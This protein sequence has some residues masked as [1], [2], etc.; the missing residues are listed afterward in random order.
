MEWR[1]RQEKAS[2]EI[3]AAAGENSD[4]KEN[5]DAKKRTDTGERKDTREKPN[6]K[7]NS[8]V[9]EGTDTGERKD[10]REKSDPKENSD[11]KK[12]TAAG[13][14]KDTREKPDSKEKSD[15]KKKAAS[16]EKRKIPRWAGWGIAV[17][18]TG[19]VIFTCFYGILDESARRWQG[20]LLESE[21]MVSLL[22]QNT[23]LLYKDL[24]NAQNSTQ[25][26]YSRL[27]LNPEAGYEWLLD[28]KELERRSES[29][30]YGDE[31]EGEETPEMWDEAVAMQQEAYE[32]LQETQ[33]LKGYFNSLEGD[34]RTLNSIFDYIVT[35]NV[36]GNYVT[37]MAAED[38]EYVINNLAGYRRYF[39]LTFRFDG[40]GNISVGEVR[41][42]NADGLRKLAN[43]IVRENTLSSLIRTQMSLF[44]QYGNVEGPK[45]CTVIYA[46]SADFMSGFDGEIILS[47]DRYFSGNGEF[48]LY[49]SKN[50]FL[51]DGVVSLDAYDSVGLFGI[52]F[53]LS[54]LFVLLGLL[55]P[56]LKDTRPWEDSAVCSLPLEI[57]LGLGLFFFVCLSLLE[58]HVA[59]LA[60]GLAESRLSESI[61]DGDFAA[62][63][64]QAYN[65]LVLGL[66]FFAFWYLGICARAVSRMGIREYIRKRSLI[67]RFFPFLKEKI[68]G[69]YDAVQH[70]DL[71]QDAHR[72]ILKLL[73]I[74]AVILFVISSL[75]FGGFFV[76]IIYS[77]LM[78]LILRKY[79]SDLQKKYRILLRAANEMAEGRLN[80]TI[81]EDLGVFEPFKPHFIRIQDGFRRAVDE[82]VKSQRMKA[83]LITNVSH[84]LK[85]PLTAI[86]TYV[87]LLQEDGITEQQ[88]KEYL[89]ILESKSL[90]L[91]C[92]IEDLFEVSKANSQNITLNLT[93]V[94]IMSLLKQVVFEMGDKLQEAG[95]DVR[96]NLTEEKV[97]LSLDSQ[98]TYRIYENLFGNIA[99]YAMRGTRVY[100]NGFRIDDTVVITLKNISAQEITV[101]S[102]EL[103]ERF[104]RG[105]ASRNTEGSGLG[106]AIAKSFTQLQG[107]ELTLEVDGDLFK[108]T[109]V[110]KL[111]TGESGQA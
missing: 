33:N 50:Y 100:V 74:N 109:T 39:L 104:V 78:Y 13:E 67:Y 72:T 43:E 90:R 49:Y 66:F 10:T 91:K 24:Y 102:A 75:W 53:C 98:K 103:T 52:L 40:V 12:R 34:F 64:A 71:T 38:A 48:H 87:N 23:Y 108:A 80:V 96:M 20:N 46:A 84:D 70:L 85:T 30:Y 29:V 25:L 99:K 105:D 22:Y 76:T 27:Y 94:D 106:L 19:A 83:E 63:L 6:P 2:A 101:D 58:Q 15:R 18:L 31:G 47:S 69:V 60:S 45:D 111:K 44:R 97:L 11:A 92:L 28:E 93:E 65:L 17:C 51:G 86:I 1:K 21:D 35:D 77:G 37:N 16:G 107:G 9:K 61:G 36:T 59:F 56:V 55:L 14:R 89:K 62:F 8:D 3:N 57:L 79:V 73:L 82:E 7:E 88:R 26:D 54:V 41:G 5:S 68:L 4:S 42:E 95:L 110:W 32:I 81:E